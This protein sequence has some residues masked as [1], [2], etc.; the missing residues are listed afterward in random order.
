MDFKI[1][2]LVK[3]CNA[4]IHFQN[5]HCLLKVF[6]VFHLY[7]IKLPKSQAVWEELRLSLLL[8]ILN[9]GHLTYLGDALTPTPPVVWVV[10]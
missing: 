9:L 3:H 7:A 4:S 10:L 8:L 2:M 1:S 6:P 5:I